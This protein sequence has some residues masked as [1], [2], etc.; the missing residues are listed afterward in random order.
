MSSLDQRMG[1]ARARHRWPLKVGL[2]LLALGA[3]LSVS[4]WLVSLCLPIPFVDEGVHFAQ[5]RQFLAG[6]WSQ[7]P[8]LTTLTLYH[9]TMAVTLMALQ[10]LGEWLNLPLAADAMAGR[11][12]EMPSVNWVRGLSLLGFSVMACMVWRALPSVYRRLDPMLDESGA[13][14]QA[15][16]QSWQW[17]W[18]PIIF[19]YLALVYTD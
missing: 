1:Y 3:C 6:D 5:I 9:A 7:H 17:L 16:R 18:L 15:N 10:T 19:P 2:V 13:Q 12:P 4:L 11:W 8:K 14:Q